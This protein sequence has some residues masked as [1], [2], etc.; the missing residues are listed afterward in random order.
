MT[1]RVFER[2]LP[3]GMKGSRLEEYMITKGLDKETL[4]IDHSRC[5]REVYSV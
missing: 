4:S 2:N 1:S 3:E 5:V